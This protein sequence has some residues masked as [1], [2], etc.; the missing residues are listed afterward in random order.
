M[1]VG[2]FIERTGQSDEWYMNRDVFGVL[3]P[4][5]TAEVALFAARSVFI[6]IRLGWALNWLVRAWKTL[7]I[8]GQFAQE[9]RMF[10]SLPG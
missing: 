7:E 4:G 9:G 5:F 1:S 3:S 2:S 8:S 10:L 6:E